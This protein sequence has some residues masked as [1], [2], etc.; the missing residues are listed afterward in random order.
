MWIN[1]KHIKQVVVSCNSKINWFSLKEVKR[2]IDGIQRRPNFK[3]NLI[4][5]HAISQQ[6]RKKGRLSWVLCLSLLGPSSA[7][8]SSFFIVKLLMSIL[9]C[10]LWCCWRFKDKA[11]HYKQY[12]FKMECP[13]CGRSYSNSQPD[14]FPRVLLLCGHTFCH[15]CVSSQLKANSILCYTCG[16]V[17]TGSTVDTFPIN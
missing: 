2:A 7:E 17:S 12:N 9:M 13:C 8:P 3:L 5:F 1:Q 16:R 11:V 14:T 4:C 15:R 6:I 10:M